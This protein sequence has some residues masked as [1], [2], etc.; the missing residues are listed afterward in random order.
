M[1]PVESRPSYLL[2]YGA[3]L[4]G[5]GNAMA[6]TFR[7]GCQILDNYDR[8]HISFYS[9]YYFNNRMNALTPVRQ[10]HMLSG[11]IMRSL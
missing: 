10:V 8:V 9:G 1:Q 11:V 5:L 6:I 7:F 3:R 4:W 2:R